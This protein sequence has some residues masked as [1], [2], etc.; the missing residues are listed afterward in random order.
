MKRY[1]CTYF[2]RNYLIKAIPMIESLSRHETVPFELFVICMD[3]ITRL[4]L[5]A[6]KLPNVT[7]IAFHEI[8]QRDTKLLQAKNNRS[9]VEYYWTTTPTI[10]LRL[11]ESY[12]RI[13]LL[14]YLDADLFFYSTPQP[15]FDELKD[16]SVLIHEHR[17]SPRLKYL[18]ENGIY[19]VGL[20]SFRNDTPGREVLIWWR[21]RCLEWCRAIPENG[22]MGDQGYLND[23]PVRF[24]K[25][26]V[27]QHLGA[28]LGPW[29][30]DQYHYEERAGEGF[31]ENVPIVFY[32]FHSLHILAPYLVLP[33]AETVYHIPFS[34]LTMCFLP[35]VRALME[36]AEMLEARFPK[37]CDTLTSTKS[38]RTDH[39][40][41]AHQGLSENLKQHNLPQIA[42]NLDDSWDCYLSP[43]VKEYS[44]II[45]TL[46]NSSQQ[47]GTD[48]S[49]IFPK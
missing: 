49:G 36:A 43:Q 27:L 13:D 9:F 44:S 33:V 5:E 21:E 3:E 2:D 25:V 28:G 11:L 45:S 19:N 40:F 7:L 17:F 48:S 29:N 35:Y 14:T 46:K 16:A 10:I 12:P 6:L 15:I 30:H 32:H 39:T 4:Y 1:Y 23:W 38:L 31:V 37:F 8:E 24:S 18:A 26:C 22:K 42:V 34:V 47:I 41:L 20:L